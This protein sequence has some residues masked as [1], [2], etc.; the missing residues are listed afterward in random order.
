MAKKKTTKT[1]KKIAKKKPDRALVIVESPAKAKTINRYLG[2]KYEVTSSMGHVRDLPKSKIGID[3]DNNFEP[4]YI[5]IQKAKKRVSQLKKEAKGK[6]HIYL[7]TDPDREPVLADL[8]V[9]QNKD[10]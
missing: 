7:A 2:S 10:L 9:C 5:V 8:N 6:T 3:V 1:T 4:H